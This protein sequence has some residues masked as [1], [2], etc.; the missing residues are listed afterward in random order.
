MAKFAIACPQCG[1]Y[2]E[3]RTGFFAKK[4]NEMGLKKWEY[5]R[6]RIVHVCL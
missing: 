5:L 6:N 2:A 1:K 3:G 4:K